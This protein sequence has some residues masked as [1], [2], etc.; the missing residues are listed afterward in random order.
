MKQV[1]KQIYDVLKNEELIK[2]LDNHVAVNPKLLHGDVE[3]EEG[4]ERFKFLRN[5]IIDEIDSGIFDEISHNRRNA[6][7]NIVNTIFQQRGN[8]NQVLS[9]IENLYDNITIS[10][11]FYRQIGKKDYENELKSLTKLKSSYTK[12]VNQFEQ[13]RKS[14]EFIAKKKTELEEVLN[15]TAEI[16]TKIENL[17]QESSNILNQ[18]NENHNNTNNVLNKIKE[19]EGDVEKRKLQIVAFHDNVDEYKNS[20]EELEQKA[21]QIIEKES[22]IDRLISEAETALKLK[23]AQGISAAFSA[24]Y[25]AASNPTLSKNWIRGAIGLLLVAIAL[26]VWIVGGW[27]IENKDEISSI[28]GRVVAVA[29]AISG[30][31]FCAK[32]YIK[33][34]NIAEDY[35]YKATLSKS[36]I[37]F[38]DEI[39]N[40][41][42][43]DG[44]QVSQYLEKVL[45]EIH[46]DPLRARDKSIE[47]TGSLTEK[48]VNIVEKIVNLFNSKN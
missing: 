44:N 3:L 31:T 47:G 19:V 13:T 33:Q 39:K 46:K 24:Q 27:G 29:I 4:V 34:K 15:N 43:E 7:Y 17:K 2:Q 1:T 35:A 5:V 40:R 25:D 32:Q 48:N 22:E 20:I 18:I 21:K 42:N 45:N 23:S 9:Q 11:L 28:I 36:I 12:F 16:K 37:A 30:A 41:E 10:G 8:P 6:I 26:T 14:L 38:T